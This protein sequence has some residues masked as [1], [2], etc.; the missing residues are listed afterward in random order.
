MVEDIN[1]VGNNKLLVLARF[2]HDNILISLIKSIS[3]T[4]VLLNRIDKVT[5]VQ[6]RM[7]LDLIHI[8]FVDLSDK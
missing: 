3:L 2:L 7:C 5:I 6:K 1:I 8:R 4:Y